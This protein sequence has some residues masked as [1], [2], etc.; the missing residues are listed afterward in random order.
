MMEDLLPSRVR[1]CGT[2]PHAHRLFDIVIRRKGNADGGVL[3]CRSS[4]ERAGDETLTV[5]RF[6]KPIGVLR[7]LRN[8][9]RRFMFVGNSSKRSDLLDDSI[10]GHV[11]IEFST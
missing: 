8:R 6:H 1:E 9:S 2:Q 10:Q 3:A 5:L 7:A 11:R 4:Q